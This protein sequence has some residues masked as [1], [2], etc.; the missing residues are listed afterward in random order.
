MQIVFCVAK[1]T[2]LFQVYIT[3]VRPRGK[4]I[5][6]CGT[7]PNKYVSLLHMAEELT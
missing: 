3:L 4:K 5:S 2:P 7:E 6:E 1:S